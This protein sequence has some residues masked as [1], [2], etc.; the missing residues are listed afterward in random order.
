VDSLSVAPNA[1]EVVRASLAGLSL[2]A[3]RDAAHL[4]LAATTVDKV[5]EAARSAAR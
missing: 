5:R 4:A 2:D 3:C 1:I